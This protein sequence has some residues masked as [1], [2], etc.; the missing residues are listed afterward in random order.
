[1][2]ETRDMCTTLGR[3]RLGLGALYNLELRAL[4]TS[5]M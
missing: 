3:E 4:N 5:T 1:M 2:G